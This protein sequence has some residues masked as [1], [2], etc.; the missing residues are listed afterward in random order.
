[1]AQAAFSFMDADSERFLKRAA[2]LQV[3][4]YRK[5]NELRKY[6]VNQAA[7]D[8]YIN[9]PWDIYFEPMMDFANVKE[10]NNASGYDIQRMGVSAGADRRVSA[11]IFVGG[12]LGI[13]SGKADLVNGGKI[14]MTAV[15]GQFYGMWF[16]QGLH[17]E[18]MIGGIYTTY[19]SGAGLDQRQGQGRH[20]RLRLHRARGRRLRL[21]KR[22]LEDRSAGG[23]AI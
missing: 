15:S 3:D 1:M 19:D 8:D 21:G 6:A 5:Y 20:H 10:D 16:E 13:G 23:H 22:P 18:A 4:Y 12:A 14:D 11:N 17:I 7:F 2:D 9:K